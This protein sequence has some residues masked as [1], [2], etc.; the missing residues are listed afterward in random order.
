MR[1][2]HYAFT[3]EAAS[4]TSIATVQSTAGAG[5]LVLDG[6]YGANGFGYSTRES[7]TSL[8]PAWQLTITAVADES[9]NTYVITYLDA[10]G[11][12]Q[13]ITTLGP[14]ATTTVLNAY[15]MQVLS[16]TVNAAATDISIG[17]VVV[18]YGPWKALPFRRGYVNSTVSVGLGGTANYSLEITYANIVDNDTFGA[19]FDFFDHPTLVNKAVSGYAQMLERV[20]GFRL[21]VNSWTSGEIRMDLAVPMVG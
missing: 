12:Q 21:K 6:T 3:P 17:H 4:P 13:S 15:A 7:K 11:V 5:S 20:V 1:A 9:A 14:N 8:R 19:T 10:N 2:R 16:V 18:G